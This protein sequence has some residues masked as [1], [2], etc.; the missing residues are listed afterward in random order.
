M[1]AVPQLNSYWTLLAA[2]VPGTIALITMWFKE[3]KKDARDARAALE[4]RNLAETNRLTSLESGLRDSERLRELQKQAYDADRVT[5]D[6]ERMT[7]ITQVSKL[8]GQ[9]SVF[10]NDKRDQDRVE[11]ELRNQISEM[12]G[13]LTAYERFGH[14]EKRAG[15]KRRDE[16]ER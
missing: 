13:E 7:L 14:Y 11:Q 6:R 1:E 10:T 2:L 5:W 15:G 4:A 9:L 3:N 12:R 8:E 16:Q